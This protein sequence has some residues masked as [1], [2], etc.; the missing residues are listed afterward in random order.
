MALGEAGMHT[1]ELL[2]T[3]LTAAQQRGYRIR[4]EDLGGDGGGGCE[5]NG[6]KWLFLD[7]AMTTR[8]QLAVVLQVLRE[9]QAEAG[10][11]VPAEAARQID[12]RR[13]A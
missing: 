6:Q 3:A 13:A 1:V 12:P 9:E 5:I 8:E 10:V 4:E 2:A 7:L 11:Q